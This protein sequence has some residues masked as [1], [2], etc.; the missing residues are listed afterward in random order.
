MLA[1]RGGASTTPHPEMKEEGGAGGFLAIVV[2]ILIAGVV[3]VVF[4]GG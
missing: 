4:L 1:G 3:Y 2:A